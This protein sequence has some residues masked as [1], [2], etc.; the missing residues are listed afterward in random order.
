MNHQVEQELQSL[1]DRLQ[2]IRVA[3]KWLQEFRVNAAPTVS[4]A[5]SIYNN[6]LVTQEEKTLAMGKRIKAEISKKLL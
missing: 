3:K 5:L 6:F 2:E 4:A 1:R